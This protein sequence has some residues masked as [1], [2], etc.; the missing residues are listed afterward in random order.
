[1]TYLRCGA[2]RAE[3]LMAPES[4]WRVRVSAWAGGLGNPAATAIRNADVVLDAGGTESLSDAFGPERFRAMLALKRI[5]LEC[6]RPLVLL[7][8]AFGP[9][10]TPRALRAASRVVR[11]ATLAWARDRRS[12][13]VLKE[14]LGSAF[15]PARHGCAPDLGFGL[16]AIAPT[17]LTRGMQCWKPR[18]KLGDEAPAAD[19]SGHGHGRIAINVSSQLWNTATGGRPGISADYREVM[20]GLITRLLER[21]DAGILLA[22]FVLARPGAPESDHAACEDLAGAVPSALRRRVGVLEGGRDPRALKWALSMADWFCAGRIPAAIA[23]LS[24]GVPGAGVAISRKTA[25]I[26][27]GVGLTGHVADLRKAGAPAVIEFLWRSWLGRDEARATLRATL[28]EAS[29]SIGGVL[30]VVSSLANGLG[31]AAIAA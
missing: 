8:Q 6:G 11:G 1:M 23:G 2:C 21:T 27:E 3:K 10:R 28:P 25:G 4:L 31:A 30:D 9:I 7:P 18:L 22:P 26:F 5:A 12:F 17:G 13:G 15:D 24:A 29:R 14:L 16:R 20:H 19:E